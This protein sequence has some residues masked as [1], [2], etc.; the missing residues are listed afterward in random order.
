[1]GIDVVNYVI[2]LYIVIV[3]VFVYFG[4]NVQCGEQWIEWVGGGVYYKGVVYVFMW[5]VV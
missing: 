2:Y 4:V 3:D 1:M 5:N